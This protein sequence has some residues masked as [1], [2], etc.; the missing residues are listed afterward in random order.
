MNIYRFSAVDSNGEQS[1]GREFW[2]EDDA[3]AMRLAAE[4]GGSM[5]RIDVWLGLR[6][7]GTVNGWAVS[8]E[9][10]RKPSQ[11]Q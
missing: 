2:C 7:V 1:D 9:R 3:A 6:K 5:R 11:L 10:S 8:G 4:M